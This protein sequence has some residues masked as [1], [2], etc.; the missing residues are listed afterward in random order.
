MV[1]LSLIGERI[2]PNFTRD[3]LAGQ[4]MT[5]QPAPFSPF[6]GLSVLLVGVGAVA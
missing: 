5:E 2:I 4:G 6:D 3:F 1:L